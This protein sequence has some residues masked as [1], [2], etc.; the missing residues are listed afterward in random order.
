MGNRMAMS[1][2][3]KHDPRTRLVELL[4][5]WLRTNAANLTLGEDE[6]RG[7]T[8]LC[9][10]VQNYPRV[11]PSRNKRSFM[12]TLAEVYE[13]MELQL[14]EV[15]ERDRTCA[16]LAAR[17]LSCSRNLISDSIAYLLLAAT[18]LKQ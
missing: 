14:R 11:F 3:Y 17:L 5:R 9:R 1:K 15:L 4:K 16:E 12:H 18:D 10:D 2:S 8:S 7:V 6:L 13:H